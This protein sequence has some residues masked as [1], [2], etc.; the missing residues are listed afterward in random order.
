MSNV[1]AF[2]ELHDVKENG[3][4]GRVAYNNTLRPWKTSNGIRTRSFCLVLS[5]AEQGNRNE[6]F[7]G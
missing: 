3:D 7:K 1:I 5:Y 4:A 6:L 2:P